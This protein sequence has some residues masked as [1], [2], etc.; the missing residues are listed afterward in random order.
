M[1][2]AAYFNTVKTNFKGIAPPPHF[3]MIFEKNISSIKFYYATKL[4]CLIAFSSR[5]I[6]EYFY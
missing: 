4:H 3:G 5:D 2:P 1:W 6:G